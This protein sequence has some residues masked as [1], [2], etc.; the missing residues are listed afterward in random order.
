MKEFIDFLKSEERFSL[1]ADLESYTYRLLSEVV[2]LITHEKDVKIYFGDNSSH[3]NIGILR[4][5]FKSKIVE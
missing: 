2:V 5:H 1:L 3:L 4:S